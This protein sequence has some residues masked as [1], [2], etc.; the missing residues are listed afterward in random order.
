MDTASLVAWRCESW[1]HTSTITT[2]SLFILPKYASAVS[3][4]VSRTMEEIPSGWC[5][6]FS[7]EL[8]HSQQHH[9]TRGGVRST[10][11]ACLGLPGTWE[12]ENQKCV[13]SPSA[14]A[15]SCISQNHT[16][17]IPNIF[18]PVLTCM[19]L[20]WLPS[21]LLLLLYWGQSLA[22]FCTYSFSSHI[23][24][25]VSQALACVTSFRYP[26]VFA[27][28]GGAAAC[29]SVSLSSNSKKLFS[30]MAWHGMA[31]RIRIRSPPICQPCPTDSNGVVM[32]P[33]RTICQSCKKLLVGRVCGKRLR[34]I[35]ILKRIAGWELEATMGNVTFLGLLR[36]ETLSLF[37]CG[38]SFRP[39]GWSW[40]G[41]SVDQCTS[42]AW[43]FRWGGD[44]HRSGLDQT[45]ASKRSRQRSLSNYGVAQ[46]CSSISEV[47]QVGGL[48]KWESGGAGDSRPSSRVWKMKMKIMTMMTHSNEVSTQCQ[49][50]PTDS[51]GE[52]V[53]PGKES[54]VRLLKPA[55]GKLC[56][57]FL[58]NDNC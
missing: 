33:E 30:I 42:W 10:C 28:F 7:H 9:D 11:W 31:W 27:S 17:S 18:L 54:L 49:P 37:H 23:V 6:F 15:E 47:A 12:S 1:K 29:I 39:Y 55:Q 13:H 53:T 4:I 43:G 19:L 22:F 2:A 3:S 44:L 36:R 24:S 40:K 5:F 50:C 21:S 38:Y 20:L 25:A 32:T 35:L 52:V 26:F 57:R 46:A 56:E 48:L 51:N 16:T 41:T 14:I 8:Y 34:C 45:L 58:L